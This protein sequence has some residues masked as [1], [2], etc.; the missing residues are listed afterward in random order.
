MWRHAD[1]RRDFVRVAD[2]MDFGAV[3]LLH[4]R[5]SDEEFACGV[6]RAS[7]CYGVTLRDKEHLAY[8]RVFEGL[9]ARPAD[10]EGADAGASAGPVA[11]PTGACEDSS[12]GDASC[13]TVLEVPG[14]PRP[15]EDP[16][17][18]CGFPLGTADATFCT[19]CGHYDVALKD[20]KV[21]RG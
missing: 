9:F 8:F 12:R 7:S 3:C 15:N 14:K 21:S 19:T 18:A 2:V 4:S 5:I 16:C 20:R 10:A 13:A 6:S 11:V 17:P 1:K